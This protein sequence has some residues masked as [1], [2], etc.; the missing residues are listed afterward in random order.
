MSVGIQEEQRDERGEH[1]NEDPSVDPSRRERE[2]QRPRIDGEGA[3]AV[4]AVRRCDEC[5]DGDR[6]QQPADRVA[7]LARDDR[8]SDQEIDGRAQRR[9]DEEEPVGAVL[10][11]Q[12]TA[13][14]EPNRGDDEQGREHAQRVGG[15]PSRTRTHRDQHMPWAGVRGVEASMRGM[16]AAEPA[17]SK[18]VAPHMPVPEPPPRSGAGIPQ[19]LWWRPGRPRRGPRVPWRADE[20]GDTR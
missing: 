3:R 2:R 11:R 18:G 13:P 9:R 12:I 15:A 4:A 1:R 5:E 16:V 17:G 7:G 19:M 10:S 14:G 6:D 8:P 20:G